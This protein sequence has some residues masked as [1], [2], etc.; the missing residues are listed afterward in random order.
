MRPRTKK[1]FLV[2]ERS[3]LDEF[4]ELQEQPKRVLIV[5]A[6]YI[7]VELAGIFA[8]LGTETAIAIRFSA[9]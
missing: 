9:K 5:G 6:G 7:A 4:F 3:I 1:K 8:S 2:F